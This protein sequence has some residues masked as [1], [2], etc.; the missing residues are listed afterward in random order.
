MTRWQEYKKRKAGMAFTWDFFHTFMIQT[1]AE[2]NRV[3]KATR[4]YNAWVFPPGPLNNDHIVAAGRHLAELGCNLKE[5]PTEGCIMDKFVTALQ[6]ASGGGGL[7][8]QISIEMDRAHSHLTSLEEM[9]AFAG[10]H[11]ERFFKDVDHGGWKQ[12]GGRRPNRDENREGGRSRDRDRP[13]APKVDNADR[14]RPADPDRRRGGRDRQRPDRGRTP[15]RG[16]SR[17][18]RRSN[19]RDGRRSGAPA[20]NGGNGVRKMAEK[21]PVGGSYRIG[22]DGKVSYWVDSDDFE[23]RV[24][25]NRCVYCD[26]DGKDGYPLHN[27]RVCPLRLEGKPPVGYRGARPPTSGR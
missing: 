24:A 13:R 14:D 16:D 27:S 25:A 6:D 21:T 1:F 3:Q 17:D 12:V 8:G 2:T 7:A 23:R 18:N 26:K 5:Q 20:S 10:K 15:S 9:V 19:S 22:K 4:E 11:A